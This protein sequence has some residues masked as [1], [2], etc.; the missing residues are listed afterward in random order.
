MLLH[1]SSLMSCVWKE[2]DVT[3]VKKKHSTSAL[4]VTN[5]VVFLT[6]RVQAETVLYDILLKWLI[7]KE[8][9]T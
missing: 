8:K 9:R 7:D 6:S 3:D 4:G 2:T 1:A 5:T